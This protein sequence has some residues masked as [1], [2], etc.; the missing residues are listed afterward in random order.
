M[1]Q[2][3]CTVTWCRISWHLTLW[4]YIT[5]APQIILWK[6]VVMR[7]SHAFKSPQFYR[8]ANYS[9]IVCPNGI[10]YDWYRFVSAKMQTKRFVWQQQSQKIY[11][12]ITCWSAC[13]ICIEAYVIWEWGTGFFFSYKITSKLIWG[14]NFSLL[15]S[16]SVWK[17]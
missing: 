12:S 8:E 11:L 9:R 7:D 4:R 16:I 5:L 13:H 2:M 14:P 1:A 3:Y 10:S 6:F 17:N 15:G